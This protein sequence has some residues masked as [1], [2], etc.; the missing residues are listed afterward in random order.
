MCCT[1]DEALVDEEE[2]ETLLVVGV[3]SLVLSDEVFLDSSFCKNKRFQVR[4]MCV[5]VANLVFHH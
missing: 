5:S 2:V 4:S 3:E 1:D